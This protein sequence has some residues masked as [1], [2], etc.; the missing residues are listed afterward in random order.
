[1]K[2]SKVS[3]KEVLEM[4][5]KSDSEEI[6]SEEDG[7]VETLHSQ[8]A[9]DP[10]PS[11]LQAS[12]MPVSASVKLDSKDEDDDGDEDDDEDE[13]EDEVSSKPKTRKLEEIS[14]E[15]KDLVPKIHPFDSSNSG[16]KAPVSN[17][18]SPFTFF[19]LFFSEKLVSEIVLE[20]N[21]FYHYS[22]GHSGESEFS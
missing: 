3:D 12:N 4:L 14:W 8:T 11:T 13:G 7:T 1:M 20:T 6:S 2:R 16:I 21:K 10:Q 18:S 17:D 5:T 22:I 9:D 19:E 15:N